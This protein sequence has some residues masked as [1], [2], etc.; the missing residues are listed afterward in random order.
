MNL[1]S[2]LATWKEV[3][4]NWKYPVIGLLI[5]LFF[6]VLN[7]LIAGWRSLVGFYS[8]NGLAK[9]LNLF[10]VMFVGFKDTLTLSSFISLVVISILLG[11]LFS[12]LIY[13]A[14]FN[15]AF[16]D[17]RLG[18]FG[19]IGAFLAAF[20]PSCAACGIGVASVLGISAGALAFLP[21]DGIEL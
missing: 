4:K 20:V 2:I 10:Y 3:F 18:V 12:M 14:H 17:K 5:A 19:G 6:Y 9:T 21:Y 13:K 8:A 1:K 16:S 7:V 11:M 15:L